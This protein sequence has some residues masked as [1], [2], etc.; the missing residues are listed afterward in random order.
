MKLP[1]LGL[2]GITIAGV[3]YS[4]GPAQILAPVT[5]SV[6]AIA[7]KIIG[8]KID[9]FERSHGEVENWSQQKLNSHMRKAGLLER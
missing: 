6:S 8:Y 7:L 1:A 2:I 9:K 4:C 3:I 5:M